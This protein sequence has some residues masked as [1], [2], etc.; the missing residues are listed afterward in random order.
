MAWHI[1]EEKPLERPP[2][3]PAKQSQVGNS[4]AEWF[5]SE[6]G[7]AVIVCTGGTIDD[8][9]LAECV[10]REELAACGIR[11]AKFSFD[12]PSTPIHNGIAGYPGWSPGE[13]GKG[14]I[15]P[16]NEVYH[17]SVGHDEDG[18]PWHTEAQAMIGPSAGHSY[19]RLNTDGSHTHYTFPQAHEPA[20]MDQYITQIPGTS[21]KQVDYHDTGDLTATDL[22]ESN[23]SSSIQKT[24]DWTDIMEKAKR[25][26]QS[27]NVMLLR[28]G[29][30]NV[31]AHVV[32]DHGEYQSEIS[33][34][35][36]NSRVITQWTCECPWDQFAFQRTRKWKKYEARPCAH[37]LA[38]YWKSL[39]T[40]LDEQLDQ[41]QIENMGTGQK[42]PGGPGIQGPPPGSTFGPSGAPVEQAGTPIEQAYQPSLP[43]QQQPG[44]GWSGQ[45]PNMPQ[46]MM[47]GMV[48]NPTTMAPSQLP[49][50]MAPPGDNQVIPPYPMNPEQLQLPV[51]VP[52]GRP[53]PYPANPLQQPGTLSHVIKVAAETEFVQGMAARINEATLG[54]SEG[55]EGATDA[56]QWMEIPRNAQVEVVYQDPS[57][58]WVEVLY[59]LKGGLMTSYHIRCF[60][61][62]EKLTPNPGAPS[63]FQNPKGKR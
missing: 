12:S 9:W 28:N 45:M 26:I 32:G 25:L 11:Q 6:P 35:D 36:P 19:F 42:L 30:N 14:I 33:R 7:I 38:T 40:P 53:G 10:I 5:E 29:Y 4:T 1:N 15:T 17:W 3:L 18:H 59:P 50:L 52:G 46:G 57:T 47:P 58:G 37:V 20:E 60:V 44:M 55:R 61:E 22:W 23:R 16:E 39:G 48:P 8:R 62:P 21:G 24:A 27:G 34:D 63:P 13:F 51:S 41:S 49:P 2:L 54:Q 43:V 31:V 56:G